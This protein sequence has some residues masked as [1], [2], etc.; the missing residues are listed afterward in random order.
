MNNAF[1]QPGCA[2]SFDYL[3]LLSGSCPH[4]PGPQ[5]GY[6][7]GPRSKS[8]S[9]DPSCCPLNPLLRRGRWLVT[10]R[11]LDKDAQRSFYIESMDNVHPLSTDDLQPLLDV[12]YIVV[13]Q[14]HVAY[15][16]RGL[17]DALSYRA[18]RKL[19]SRLCRSQSRPEACAS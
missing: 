10:G 8:W 16:A 18:R 13:E 15:K 1:L 11:D 17:G 19:G 5:G 14:T 3:P 2:Y 4:R 12:E 6:R 7:F 9:I